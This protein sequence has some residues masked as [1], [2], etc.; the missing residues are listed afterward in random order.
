MKVSLKLLSFLRYGISISISYPWIHILILTDKV[1][2]CR[3]IITFK[4]EA[5][6]E[7]L[8]AFSKMK[9]V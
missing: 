1:M 6:R 7:A 9:I 3:L 4:T 2:A 5:E 8:E